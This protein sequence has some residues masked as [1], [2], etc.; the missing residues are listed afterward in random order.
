MEVD[1]K[2]TIRKFNSICGGAKG[3]HAPQMLYAVEAVKTDFENS[4]I[5]F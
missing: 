4:T 3:S 5:V 1:G 2:M